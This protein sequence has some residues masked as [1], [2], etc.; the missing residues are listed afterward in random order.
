MR[1]ARCMRS[2][3]GVPCAHY[4]R[5]IDAVRPIRRAPSSGGGARDQGLVGL[6]GMAPGAGW[7]PGAGFSQPQ[8]QS[9]VN[10]DSPGSQT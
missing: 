2:S 4:V 8:P 1:R 9:S 7:A 6:P 5:C 10:W 3:R